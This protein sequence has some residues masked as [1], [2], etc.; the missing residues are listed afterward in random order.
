MNFKAKYVVFSFVIFIIYAQFGSILTPIQC[1]FTRILTYISIIFVVVKFK[2][3]FK[4]DPTHSPT[5]ELAETAGASTAAMVTDALGALTVAD[6]LKLRSSDRVLFEEELELLRCSGTIS[7]MLE[8][9]GSKTDADFI[10]DLPKINAKILKLVLRWSRHHQHDPV[11][12]VDTNLP[13]CDRCSTDISEWDLQFFRVDDSTLYEIM[14]AANFLDIK[15][16][17]GTAAKTIAN[18]IKSK[19]P[20]QIKML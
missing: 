8:C 5:V 7:T 9:C 14:L 10:L 16:L 3:N 20:E 6:T 11:I 1:G 15:E 18:R 4:M 12:E 17:L 13:P 2:V 19:T